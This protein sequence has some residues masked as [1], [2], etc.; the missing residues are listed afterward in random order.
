MAKFCFPGRV[1]GQRRFCNEERRAVVCWCFFNY[2]HLHQSNANEQTA[3]AAAEIGKIKITPL[4]TVMRRL[5][6]R[7]RILTSGAL[8]E[9][10]KHLSLFNT[11]AQQVF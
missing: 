7:H 11:Y 3:A 10:E 2:A 9:L 4:L 1:L 5:M 6:N 8:S